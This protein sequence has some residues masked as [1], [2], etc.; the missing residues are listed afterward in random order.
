MKVQQNNNGST[1][2]FYIENEN[3]IIATLS[4]KMNEAG[5]MVIEHTEVLPEGN[6]KGLG[7]QLVSAAVEFARQH[8]IKIVPVCPFAKKIIEKI[9]EYQDV[10]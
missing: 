9:P 7:K 10:L 4:Y 2:G 8:A 5:C 1:S 6:G 3:G